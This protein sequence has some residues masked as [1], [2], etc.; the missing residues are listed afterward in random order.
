M[1]HVKED[2]M[3]ETF[4]SVHEGENTMAEKMKD[5]P[6]IDALKERQDFLNALPL[7]RRKKMIEFQRKIDETFGS[8]MPADERLE[9]I[10]RMMLNKADELKRKLDRLKTN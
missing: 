7:R 8:I 9:L 3:G 4:H 1:R 10:Y 6:L 5:N 2:K